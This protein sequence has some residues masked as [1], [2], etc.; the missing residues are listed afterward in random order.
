MT[1]QRII[2]FMI[3]LGAVAS[4]ANIVYMLVSAFLTSEFEDKIVD[5]TTSLAF[6]V[7]CAF[8]LRKEFIKPFRN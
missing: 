4:F 6:F 8:T 1:K 2:K 3:A 7:I 5:F